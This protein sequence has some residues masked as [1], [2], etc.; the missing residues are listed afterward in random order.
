MIKTEITCDLCGSTD[1]GIRAPFA[2]SWNG[3]SFDLCGMCLAPLSVVLD[4][5]WLKIQQRIEGVKND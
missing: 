3:K 4:D 5:I 2:V 1:K